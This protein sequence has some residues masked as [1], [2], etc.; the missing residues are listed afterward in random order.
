MTGSFKRHTM[1]VVLIVTFTITFLVF[2]PSPTQAVVPVGFVTTLLQALPAVG[3]VIGKLL[4][5]KS[6]SSDQKK[7]ITTLETTSN[8]GKK[9]LATYAQR[10]QVIW[11]LVSSSSLISRAA[12]GMTV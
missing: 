8:D 9:Q 2:Q 3:T 6:P 7:A 10:E 4:G 5:G 1:A 11:R 12:S